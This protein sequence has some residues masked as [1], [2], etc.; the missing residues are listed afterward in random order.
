MDCYDDLL[1]IPP[2]LRRE[3]HPIRATRTPRPR[4]I[5]MP[6]RKSRRARLAKSQR[7]DPG[8]V[9]A[10]KAERAAKRRRARRAKERS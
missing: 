5:V 4:K 10:L 9:A 1:D 6:K 2:F 7:T 8:Y 3:S